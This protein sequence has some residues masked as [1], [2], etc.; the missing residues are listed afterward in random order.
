M[1]IPLDETPFVDVP[2]DDD[3]G[4]SLAAT[5]IYKTKLLAGELKDNTV[6]QNLPDPSEHAAE[7]R[8]EL[9]TGIEVE[10]EP[11]LLQHV[12]LVVLANEPCHRWT[13]LL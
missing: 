5:L 11:F 3:K 4:T 10:Q 6:M 1:G 8:G 7:A 2:G 9:F 13:L 12:V